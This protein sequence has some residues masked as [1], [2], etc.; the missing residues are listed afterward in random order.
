[1]YLLF[2]VFLLAGLPDSAAAKLRYMLDLGI[3][4]PLEPRSFRNG[5]KTGFNFGLGVEQPMTDRVHLRVQ[6]DASNFVL[7]SENYLRAEGLYE[8][9]LRVE[10][11]DAIILTLATSAK[12]MPMKRS[13]SGEAFYLLLGGGL[14]R[15][16]IGDGN[17]I[18]SNDILPR[19]GSG[20]TTVGLNAGFGVDVR[21]DSRSSFFLEARY[22]LG[23]TRG[24]FTSHIPVRVGISFR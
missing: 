1:M 11:G 21:I 2:V 17:F 6:V 19:A 9:G 22:V 12:I 5:W 24:D 14:Y 13:R 4:Y 3:A 18:R 7:D 16:T 15:M 8:P 23:L 10:G 20:E